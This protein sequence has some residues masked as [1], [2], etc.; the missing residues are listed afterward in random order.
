M[1]DPLAKNSN[2]N[3]YSRN[4]TGGGGSNSSTASKVSSGSGGKNRGTGVPSLKKK[5]RLL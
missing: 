2:H 3:Y 1:G 4:V 5:K